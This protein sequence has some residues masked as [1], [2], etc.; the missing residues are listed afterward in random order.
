MSITITDLEG[1]EHSV[2]VAL[3]GG[4]LSAMVR[5]PSEEVFDATAL[6]VG[7]MEHTNPAIPAVIDL[8]TEEVITEA[9]E[10]SGPLKPV[11][12]VTITKIGKLVLTPGT[13]DEE[14]NELTAPVVD[15]RYHVNFWLGPE[16]AAKGEWKKWAIQWSDYGQSVEPNAEES[17]KALNSIELIDPA[18]VRSPSNVML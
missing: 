1:N 17:A 16:L 10:A 12:H 7:L 8:E 18:T 4:R 13:Y 11:K 15:D 3:S 5:C 9:V 2:Y 6:S 14:G